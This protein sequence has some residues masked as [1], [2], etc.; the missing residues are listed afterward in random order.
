MYLYTSGLVGVDIGPVQKIPR[1]ESEQ[2]QAAVQATTKLLQICSFPDFFNAAAQNLAQ[3]LDADAAALIVTDGPA[4]LKYRLFYGLERIDQMPIMKFSFPAD[5]G[6]VGHAFTTGQF[7]FTPDYQNSPN[8]MPEFVAAGLRANLVLPLPGPSGFV[9]AIAIA[10]LHGTAPSLTAA[11]LTIAELFA[12]LIG[13]A[14][15]RE[16]L[17]RQLQDHSFTDP[18]TGL[19]NR[20]ML[21]ARL[22]EAQQRTSRNQTLMALAVLDLD[23]FKAVNDRFGHAVG[24]QSLLLA[25]NAIR[26]VIRESDFAARLGGDEFVIVLEDLRSV[27]EVAHVL[28]RIVDAIDEQGRKGAEGWAVTASLGATVYPLD[29]VG[30]EVLLQNA[31][32]AMYTAK[33]AGGNQFYLLASDQAALPFVSPHLAERRKANRLLHPL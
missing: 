4:R 8:A 31:D 25:A 26:G 16:G 11:M 24:D 21:M 20:R 5:R 2:W 32:Q 7:L 9:G 28:R 29:L 33:R 19:P 6:T 27:S 17:E 13:S 12:A 23:G 22:E 10:W 1:N 15:Y 18:L 30:P 3:L 14:V